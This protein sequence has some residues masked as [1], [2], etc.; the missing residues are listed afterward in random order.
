MRRSA[1][2]APKNLRIS[3]LYALAGAVGGTFWHTNSAASL[4]LVPTIMSTGF[5]LPSA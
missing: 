1:T 4:R 2:S 5:T 3:F